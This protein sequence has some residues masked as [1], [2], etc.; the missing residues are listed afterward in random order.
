MFLAASNFRGGN[1][2]LVIKDFH[3]SVVFS[4]VYSG[5]A[6]S[7]DR[8]NGK[9][10][11]VYDEAEIEDLVIF[12]DIDNFLSVCTVQVRAYFV[13]AIY[14]RDIFPKGLIC[15]R[16]NH[17]MVVGI[18]VSDFSN[19]MRVVVQL[20]KKVATLSKARVSVL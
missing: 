1:A 9:T 17:V 18:M 12:T 4:I 8:L 11:M 20:L 3:V 2:D 5:A 13:L 15:S 6:Y 16:G 14:V 10:F 19:Q 7:V